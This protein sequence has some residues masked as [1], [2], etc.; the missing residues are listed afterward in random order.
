[1]LDERKA[2]I[3]LAIVRE[4]IATGQPVGSALVAREPTV[5]VSSAT[6]RNEMAVL[7]Q[8]GYLHQPH[9]SAGR[10]PT[11]KAYRV[12]VDHLTTPAVC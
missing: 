12:F 9:T 1:M 8:E 2:A 3:L 10:V 5:Q 11:D 4:Y 7:E 6:V